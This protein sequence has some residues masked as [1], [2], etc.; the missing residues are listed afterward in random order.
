VV[1]RGGVSVDGV[2][3][4]VAAALRHHPAVAQ[5][6]SQAQ[7]VRA[8]DRAD[9]PWA[10]RLALLRELVLGQVPVRASGSAARPTAATVPAP[11]GPA[12]R[13]PWPSAA[14][15]VARPAE[16]TVPAIDVG[17]RLVRLGLSPSGALQ[18]PATVHVAGWYD[19]GPRPGAPGPAV[20]AGHMDSV[21]G[22]GV[23]YQ[24]AS[25]HSGER[26]YVR[27]T[28]GTLVVFRVT[29]VRMYR[30]TRFPTTA[31]YGPAYGP[32]LR[33]ITCGGTFD[34]ARRSYLSNVVVYA[35]AVASKRPGGGGEQA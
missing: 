22:P 11:D 3:G 15:P 32:Q 12:A 35:V 1:I 5:G 8:A 33:L 34:R 9:L 24:L 17:T 6:G 18:V 21:S 14:A 30:K 13:I 28:D 10:H 2:L 27:R 4:G 19:H 29:A 25:L 31:V 16:L 26:I 23:F 7:S 20:I